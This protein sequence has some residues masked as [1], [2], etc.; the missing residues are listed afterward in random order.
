ME[1]PGM[2][3]YK[4]VRQF[5]VA[6]VVWGVVGMLVGVVIAAQLLTLTACSSARVVALAWVSAA[7][8]ALWSLATSV[9]AVSTSF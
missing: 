3:N 1:S 4:V 6:A 5:A 2:Y 7:N 9:W 8:T